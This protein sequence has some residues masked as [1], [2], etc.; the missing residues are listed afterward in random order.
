M[1]TGPSRSFLYVAV[2]LALLHGFPCVEAKAVYDWSGAGALVR[3]DPRFDQLVP[4][5]ARLEKIADGFAWLEG[6]VWSR[7]GQYLLFSDVASNAVFKWK[8]GEG[9]SLFLKP[10]A[11]PARSRFEVG[12]LARMGSR[13]I[14]QG[15]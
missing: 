1:K 5:D 15:G 4:P 3:A 6:P 7:E 11:T 10:R 9:V 12:S 14:V 2:T 8:E 13:L